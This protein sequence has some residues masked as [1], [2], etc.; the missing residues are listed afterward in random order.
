MT[1]SL[2]LPPRPSH[3]KRLEASL[4]SLIARHG[5]WRVIRASLFAKPMKPGR[6]ED[7]PPAI[8]RDLGLP[9][10]DPVLPSQRQHLL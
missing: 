9:P 4:R 5:R 3:S 10:P 8:R 1:Y 6:L 7:L 2:T